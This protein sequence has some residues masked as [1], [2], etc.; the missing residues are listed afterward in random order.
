VDKTKFKKLPEDWFYRL[1]VGSKEYMK[2]M[3]Y[4]QKLDVFYKDARECWGCPPEDKMEFVG[5]AIFE[6]NTYENEVCKLLATRTITVIEHILNQ[7]I[8][9]YLIDPTN[10][11]VYLTVVNMVFLSDK[12]DW[13]IS[14]RS[15]WFDKGNPGETYSIGSMQIPKSDICI[16]L[17]ELLKWIKA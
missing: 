9:D 7:T 10:N 15:A 2:S 16:F 13:G 4:T 1:L 11:E 17:E 8:R 3:T 5:L 12:L 6:Y 14:I